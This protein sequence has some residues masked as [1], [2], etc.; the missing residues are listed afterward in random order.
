MA[1]DACSMTGGGLLQISYNATSLIF[2]YEHAKG[3]V[4]I[5]N[6]HLEVDGEH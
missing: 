5:A 2:I 1:R 6:M 3:R 4:M